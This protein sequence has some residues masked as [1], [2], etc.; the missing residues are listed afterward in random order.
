M[1]G[2][3]AARRPFPTGGATGSSTSSGKRAGRGRG[4]SR[5][6]SGMQSAPIPTSTPWSRTCSRSHRTT[7]RARSGSRSWATYSKTRYPTS[8]RCWAGKSRSERGRGYTTRRGT[9]QGTSATGPSYRTSRDQALR[10]TR[11]T[12]SPS[13]PATS[14]SS[15]RGSTESGYSIPHADPARS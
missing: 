9:S 15:T 10:E 13:T 2:G 4:S 12:L 14:T 11:T 5:I 7:F 8:R 6:R 1:T 3:R